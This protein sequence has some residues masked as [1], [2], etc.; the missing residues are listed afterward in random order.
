MP[1]QKTESVTH[2]LLRYS[3]GFRTYGEES[4]LCPIPIHATRA[5]K[6]KPG[7]HFEMVFAEDGKSFTVSWK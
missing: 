4:V 6:L 5:L 1:D 3:G 2:A 7:Q